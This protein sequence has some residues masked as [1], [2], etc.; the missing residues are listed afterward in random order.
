MRTHLSFIIRRQVFY[1]ANSI[2]RQRDEK[3]R[4][5]SFW[6]KLGMSNV[7]LLL[8]QHPHYGNEVLTEEDPPYHCSTSIKRWISLQFPF[9]TLLQVS[10]SRDRFSELMETGPNFDAEGEIFCLTKRSTK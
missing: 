7:L 10:L 5:R 4:S 6:H 2:G 3:S 1:F 9:V 8:G